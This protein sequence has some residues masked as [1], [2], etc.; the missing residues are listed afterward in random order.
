MSNLKPEDY[1]KDYKSLTTNL[2]TA[3]EDT[4]AFYRIKTDKDVPLFE[5]R[6]KKSASRLVFLSAHK[7]LRYPNVTCLSEKKF[8]E[9]QETLAD[10]FYPILEKTNICGVT[11]TN[12]KTTVV[13]LCNNLA[14]ILKKK[15]LSIGTLGV[16]NQAGITL[17]EINSTTPSYI[18]L[19]RIISTYQNEYQAFF[20]EV[21]SHGLEQDRMKGLSFCAAGW[22]SFSQD[23]LDYHHSMQ[24]YFN[25]KLK[26]LEHLEK[27]TC[28]YV[29]GSEHE[30][31][32]KL[33]NEERVKA[34]NKLEGFDCNNLLPVFNISYNKSNL[35]VALSIVNTLW[36]IEKNIDFKTMSPPPGR[37]SLIENENKKVI[38]DYAHTPDALENISHAVRNEYPEHYLIIVFG[39]GGD[40]DPLK[41]PLMGQAAQLY[42][43]L[44]IVTSDN[45]RSEDP[46]DIISQIIKGIEKGINLIV[47][48]DRAKA[49]EN[50]LMHKSENK[51]GDVI[52][53]AGKGHENYQE[54]K[55]V[56]NPFS[57]F[58]I[59]ENLW[60]I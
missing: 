47:E 19:R 51:H 53:I 25:A 39:C 1:L 30:L 60:K 41:R 40:R 20:I 49:I 43:D 17:E 57:D 59:I 7:E 55:G 8:I 13:H 38:I 29:P 54:I 11:G 37:F 50:A 26:I 15:T 31:L 34:A 27:E 44:L 16:V 35:E 36:K 6:L 5:Q 28:L 18:D 45:P 14:S 2:E 58:T 4:I 21:S 56:K 42:A 9:M 3:K 33:K 46:K 52:I 24:E 32:E 10:A 12:G 23:H 22:T 48:S